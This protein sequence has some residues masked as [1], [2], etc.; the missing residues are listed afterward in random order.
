[1]LGRPAH[2]DGVKMSGLHR[3]SGRNLSLRVYT[4]QIQLQPATN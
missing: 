4:C 1:M 2:G 3:L